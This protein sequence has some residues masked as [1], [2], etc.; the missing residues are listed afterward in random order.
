VPAGDHTIL[1]V[2]DNDDNREVVARQLEH[3]GFRVEEASSGPEALERVAARAP[4]LI[5]LDINM[6][7]MTGNSMA[8]RNKRW[9]YEYG[10]IGDCDVGLQSPAGDLSPS[11]AAPVGPHAL[12]AMP[13]FRQPAPRQV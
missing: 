11:A 1:V 2:D 6:P 5:L 4:S 8:R 9:R 12:R 13:R 3:A 10:R 7:K